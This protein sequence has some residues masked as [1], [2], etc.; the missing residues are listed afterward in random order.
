MTFLQPYLVTVH[1]VFPV[2]FAGNAIHPAVSQRNFSQSGRT[3]NAAVRN[4]SEELL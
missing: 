1:Y 3:E 2:G 4:L